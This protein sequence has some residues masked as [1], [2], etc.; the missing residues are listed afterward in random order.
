MNNIIKLYFKKF[1]FKIV[2]FRGTDQINQIYFYDLYV[3]IRMWRYHFLVAKLLYNYL[4]PSVR[5]S[6]RPYVRFS[7]KRDFLSP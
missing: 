4:C 6:V 2:Y 3:I 1:N 5:P 7:G